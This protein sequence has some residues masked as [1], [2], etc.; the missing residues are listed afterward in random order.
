MAKHFSATKTSRILGTILLSALFVFAVVAAVAHFQSQSSHIAQLESQNAAMKMQL[1]S[2]KRT[3]CSSASNVTVGANPLTKYDIQ[4]GG[5]A[6]TY[7]VHT[8]NNY[9][10]SV[11]YPV[12]ISFDGIEGSGARMEAYSGLDVLPAILVYP[13]ALPGKQ[14]FTSWEGA[15]YSITGERDVQ[16]VSTLLEVLPS[17][18]CTDSTRTYAVGMSNG[19]AFATIVGCQLGNQIQAV[20]SVSG[21]NYETCQQQ[22]RT[23]SLLIVHSTTDRQVPFMGSAARRLPEIPK[24]ADEQVILRQCE[25]TVP[26]ITIATATYYTW[27]DCTDN[28]RLRLV[29][30]TGQ[31]HGWLTIP[32]ASIQRTPGS[33]GYI[34]KFFEE[35]T[36]D[37]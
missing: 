17:Q 25:T 15:P 14:G 12:V 37:D 21:A 4:S 18:Y 24:W 27:L 10:P 28:S 19:G 8:P 5:H 16:F 36:Y 29:V 32:D 30:L 23:P 11:R 13:D 6:R 3:L 2:Y 7:Q 34:W 35:S 22:E 33:A 26:S 9:D 1:N 31:A 20:A